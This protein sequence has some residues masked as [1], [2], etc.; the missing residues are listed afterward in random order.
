MLTKC[1]MLTERLPSARH[2]NNVL[3]LARFV[4]LRELCCFNGISGFQI[5]S[6]WVTDCSVV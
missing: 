6:L 3:W 5:F 1:V 4:S 2:Y